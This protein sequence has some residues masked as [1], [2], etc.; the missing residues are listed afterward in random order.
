M[1]FQIKILNNP[2]ICD[3]D[4]ILGLYVAEGWWDGPLNKDLVLEII[5][6]SHIFVAAFHGE[7]LIGMGRAISDGV[8]DAYIQDVTVNKDYRGKS[9]GALIINKIIDEL[10]KKNIL[11]IGLISEKNSEGFY[12]KLGFSE[13][14][15]TYPMKYK[16]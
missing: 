7:K 3:I 5:N 15:N 16:I 9:L 14:E 13:M 4:E 11:W 1:K 2:L 6:G 12:K 10:K 8:S